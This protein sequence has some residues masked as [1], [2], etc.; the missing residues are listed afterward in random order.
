MMDEL[1]NEWMDE[2]RNFCCDD[3]A[4]IITGYAYA[5]V[6]THGRV[7]QLDYTK[8]FCDF[9]PGGRPSSCLD[10]KIIYKTSDSDPDNCT[11]FDVNEDRYLYYER[12]DVLSKYQIFN[13]LERGILIN[14]PRN[15]HVV[16]SGNHILKMLE[17]GILIIIPRRFYNFER[18]L[19]NNYLYEIIYY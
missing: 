14:P 12:S 8:E 4:G 3:V 7:Y 13:L 1:M 18:Y 5:T 19:Y 11:I 9:N 16:L 6:T 15:S 2:L 17:R 10:L